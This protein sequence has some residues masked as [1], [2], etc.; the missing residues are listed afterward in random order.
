MKTMTC[1]LLAV[2]A[3]SVRAAAD[4]P[5]PGFGPR[6]M[7]M[8]QDIQTYFDGEE[9]EGFAWLAL[10]GP[11][12]GAGIVA[13]SQPGDLAKGIAAPTL[14]LGGIHEFIGLYLLGITEGRVADLRR[15]FALDPRTVAA[16]EK[17]RIDGVIRGFKWLTGIE[18]GLAGCGAALIAVGAA[19]KE[20]FALGVGIGLAVESLVTLLL[21]NFA[22]RRAKRYAAQLATFLN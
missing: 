5:P 10:G 4:E 12:L 19:G 21:D 8:S 3:L 20:D 9:R 18:I 15:N 1:A 7:A 6:E 22:W 11:G 14:L 13:V 2:F 17:V 16:A